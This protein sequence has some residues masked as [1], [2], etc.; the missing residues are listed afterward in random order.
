MQ[1]FII[2]KIISG[3]SLAII[4][5]LGMLSGKTTIWASEVETD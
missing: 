3:T 1:K 2:R 4:A 5:M